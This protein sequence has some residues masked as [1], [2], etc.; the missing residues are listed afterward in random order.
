MTQGLVTTRLTQE[1]QQE[2]LKFLSERPLHTVVM[3]G[4]IR[5]NGME[6][7]FNRGNFYACRQR[8]RSLAGVALIGH[9]MFVDARSEEALRQFAALAHEFPHTHMMLGEREL[10]ERF[11]RY[12]APNGQLQRRFC[13]EV[14]FEL[15]EPSPQF[16]SVSALRPATL[17]EQ[18][19][20]V[21]VHAALAFEESG[22][23]PLE[24]DPDGF[25]E[26]CRRRIEE[27][28][29]W[30]LIEDSELIFKADVISDT[31]A[32]VYLEG[33]YVHPERRGTG[34]GSRCLSELARELLSRT[35]SISLLV[36]QERRQAQ[37]FFRK[38]GFVSRGFY[39]TIFLRTQANAT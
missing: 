26:R 2:V 24:V 16:E 3:A 15:M 14:L 28:R 6:S 8:D 32:V 39:D 17:A 30:V 38:L 11:W 23:N 5:D 35:K 1:D 31:D 19:L 7:E 13:R 21:P 33:I 22:V 34:Y 18:S 25:R 36:D 12:Y 4:L 9:A 37:N 10:I 20:I 27:Q 29:V